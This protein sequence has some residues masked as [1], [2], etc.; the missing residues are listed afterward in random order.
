LTDE[1]DTAIADKD[2]GTIKDDLDNQN[3]QIKPTKPVDED[4]HV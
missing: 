4:D 3:E 1:N 2:D